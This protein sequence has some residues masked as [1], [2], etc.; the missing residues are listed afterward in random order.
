[1]KRSK[2]LEKQAIEK[3]ENIKIMIVE[4]NKRL[5]KLKFDN[6]NDFQ[7]WKKEVSIETENMQK[8]IDVIHQWFEKE[9]ISLPTF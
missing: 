6:K 9:L 7:E 1:M 8:S 2:G 4:N 5:Q 3:L